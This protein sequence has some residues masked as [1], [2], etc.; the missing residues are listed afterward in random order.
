M[1][2][3]ITVPDTLE[4]LGIQ[5]DL[6]LIGWV[7][8]EKWAQAHAA[9]VNGFLKASYAAKQIMKA[10]DAEW[11]RLRP[12]MKADDDA[13]FTALRD[14]FRAGIPACFGDKEKQEQPLIPSAFWPKSAAK[15]W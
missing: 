14:G 9:S 15:N 2:S 5:R 3:I 10:D 11:V 6:P 4:G 7:F 12:R 8:S 1:R 13:V